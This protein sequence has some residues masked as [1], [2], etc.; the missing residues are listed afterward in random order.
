MSLTPEPQ[1]IIPPEPP[2]D[3]DPTLAARTMGQRIGE[4][5]EIT[6][7]PLPLVGDYRSTAIRE[8][9]FSGPLVINEDNAALFQDMLAGWFKYPPGTH[10][11]TDHTGRAQ[12]LSVRIVKDVLLTVGLVSEDSPV[13]HLTTLIERLKDFANRIDAVASGYEPAVIDCLVNGGLVAET[14]IAPQAAYGVSA[15][16]E[17]HIAQPRLYVW[18]KDE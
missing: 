9:T 2:K 11:I 8:L 5:E 6:V 14:T 12:T 16:S 15:P 10:Q 7:L 13:T 3:R 4:R 18:R 1:P 17:A